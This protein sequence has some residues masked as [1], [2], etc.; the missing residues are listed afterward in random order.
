MQLKII[1]ILVK[2]LYVFSAAWSFY[3][4]NQVVLSGQNKLSI[5]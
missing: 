1:Q 4:C 3:S 5:Y 2:L